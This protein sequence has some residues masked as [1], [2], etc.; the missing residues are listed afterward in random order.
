MCEGSYLLKQRVKH[1]GGRA[2]LRVQRCSLG[3]LRRDRLA[4]QHQSYMQWDKCL[5][6]GICLRNYYGSI[7][8]T[9]VPLY[10][11]STYKNS[12]YEKTYW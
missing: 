11:I 6:K 4:V 3:T 2:K 9:F 12:F 1:F 5:D 10:L 7:F 8:I